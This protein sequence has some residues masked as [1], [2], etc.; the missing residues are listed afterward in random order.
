MIYVRDTTYNS[1]FVKPRVQFDITDSWRLETGAYL[2]DGQ[3]AEKQ[4]GL[5]RDRDTFYTKLTYQF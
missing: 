1:W 2:I 3:K 4:F 5:F